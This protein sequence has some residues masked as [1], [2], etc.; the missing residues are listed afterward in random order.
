MTRRD[1]LAHTTES[2]RQF[3]AEREWGQFHN[4]K[5]LAMTLASEAGELLSALR[6]VSDTESDHVL[7]SGTVRTRVQEEIADIAIALIL[8]CDRA[9][10]DLI[11][12]IEAKI[13]ANAV[14]YPVESSRG[15]PD[16]SRV[17]G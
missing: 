8:L 16:R 5:N 3:V 6:W 15:T 10:I 7:R 11:A 12:A 2:L 13:A 1:T 14:N 9:D 4:P 17:D